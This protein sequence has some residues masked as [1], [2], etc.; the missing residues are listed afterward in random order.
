MAHGLEVRV[1]LIGNAVIDSVLSQPSSQHFDEDGGKLILRMLAKRHLPECV[2][3][4]PK[5]GFSVPLRDLFKG[6]WQELGDDLFS[7]SND[8]APFIN[9]TT[10]QA[11]WKKSRT[12]HGQIRLTYSLLV[13]LLWLDLHGPSS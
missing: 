9:A 3:N 11:L 8:I 1:P 4:R 2:W 10:A 6:P 7:R 13:L 12:G 5:H